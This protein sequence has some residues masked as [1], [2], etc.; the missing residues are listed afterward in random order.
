VSAAFRYEFRMQV[1]KRSMWLANGVV[2]LLLGLLSADQLVD[3]LHDPAAKAAMTSTALLVNLILPVGYG[4]FLADRLVRD[5]RLGVAPILDTTPAS[6]GGRLAGKYLGSCAAAAIPLAIVHFG[7][8]ALYA[9]T[10]GRPVALGWA[11]ALFAVVIVPAV[12]FVGA[13][14]LVVPLLIPAPLF[15]VLFV[16]YWF[17]GNALSPAQIP[18]LAQSLLT[19][20]GAYPL[21]AIFGYRGPDGTVRLAGP[22]PGAAFNLLRPEATALTAWLSIGVLL[23]LAALVLS[24]APTLRARTTR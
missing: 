18:T 17:W 12:L 2:V 16:G 20:V 5:D 11:V 10:A 1:R 23:A 14:A 15:R 22:V 13:F 6:A 4:C 9:A 3:V 21:Q 24:A 19:P 8:A 7:F